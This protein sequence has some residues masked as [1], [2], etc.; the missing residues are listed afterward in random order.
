MANAQSRYFLFNR[1]TA[2]KTGTYKAVKNV[3]TREQARE[4]R[5]SSTQSLGIY[6]R[7]NDSVIS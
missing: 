7:W 1:N 6:D 5:R 4:A 2:Q 3:S